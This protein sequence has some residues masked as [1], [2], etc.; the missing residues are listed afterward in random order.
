MTGT[1]TRVELRAAPILSVKVK[2]TVKNDVCMSLRLAA[3]GEFDRDFGFDSQQWSCSNGLRSA[4]NCPESSGKTH[5]RSSCALSPLQPVPRAC[6]TA[7]K[8]L[9]Q[10]PSGVPLQEPRDQGEP[11]V[12]KRNLFHCHLVTIQDGKLKER[13]GEPSRIWRVGTA[14]W[15]VWQ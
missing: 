5:Q 9:C 7:H 11:P 8:T 1:R 2:L 3:Y 12:P 13:V 15:M 10:S 4:Q 14:A 6:R